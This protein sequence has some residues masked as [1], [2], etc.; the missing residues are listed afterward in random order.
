MEESISSSCRCVLIKAASTLWQRSPCPTNTNR[1][2]HAKQNQQQLRFYYLSI[3]TRITN[4]K[5]MQERPLGS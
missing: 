1:V 4:D 5:V 2:A 3:P